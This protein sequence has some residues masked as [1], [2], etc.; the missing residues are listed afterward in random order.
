MLLLSAR[1]WSLCDNTNPNAKLQEPLLG[2]HTAGIYGYTHAFG[3]YAGAHAQYVRVP[4]ADIDCFTVPDGLRDEQVLFLSDA[5]PT[6]YMGAD[7]CVTPGS[8]VAVWG[9]GGVGL[10]AQRSA[11]LLGADRVIAIDR[12][13]RAIVCGAR[14]LPRRDDRLLVL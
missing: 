7:L 14:A 12:L 11:W 10:M 5:A 8:V 3:G 6:G 13:R 1:L 2:G 9:C 4:H